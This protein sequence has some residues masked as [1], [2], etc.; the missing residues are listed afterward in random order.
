MSQPLPSI[1]IVTP[2]FNQAPFLA[3]TI[4]SVL[5]QNYPNLEYV[6]IDGGSTDGSVE[7]I[8][9]YEK[10]LA[11]WVSEPDRGQYDAI[12]KGFA[13]TKGD[14]MAWI[15]SDDK[16]T[17]WTLRVAS[18]IFAQFQTVEWLTTNYPLFAGE[19]GI[20]ADCVKLHGF[21]REA[22]FRGA[23]LPGG[24]WHADF[25]IQ[26]ESTF[27]RRSLWNRAGNRI[28][29]GLKL[30]GD[31]ELWA[32]FFSEGAELHGVNVPL[33]C[34]RH[35]KTQRSALQSKEY[36]A[37]ALEVLRKNGGKPYS[38]W[39][40]YVLSKLAMLSRHFQKRYQRKL[41]GGKPMPVCVNFQ[42]TG[43]SIKNK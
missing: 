4:E 13:R 31:F 38:K 2:S 24:D 39:E 27:W 30:A 15:N 7:I 16:H 12:N 34:F 42:G 29:S 23:N 33:A 8:R 3:E 19:Q 43:W 17:P 10:H 41:G 6:I 36:F 35:Q 22:F 40:S 1:S 18:E 32:R 9:K 28:D 25:F 5:G 20:A 37:E 14:I 21:N 11:Y 26:Q